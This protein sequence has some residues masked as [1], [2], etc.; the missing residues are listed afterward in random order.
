VIFCG[1]D[2]SMCVE[3]SLR[4][5]FNLGFDII[6]VSDGTAYMNPKRYEYTLDDVRSFYGLVL[7]TKELAAEL[8]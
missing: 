7:D 5:T 3:M 4:D 8:S 1:F 6:F 2:T